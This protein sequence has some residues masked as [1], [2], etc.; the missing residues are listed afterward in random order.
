MEIY[1]LAFNPIDVNTWIVADSSG[2]CA[3]IDCG[4]YDMD[5]FREFTD[6]LHEKNLKPVLLLN[7]HC[8]LDHI[9][10]DIFMKGKYGLGA[11]CHR[12]D[13]FNRNQSVNHALMFGLRM[14]TPPDPS[15]F[16][17]DNMTFSFGT[18]EI[19][20]LH[21][22][23]HAPGSLA[24]Y[25][26]KENVVFT[27]DALF[28]GSIGRTDLPGGNYETIINSIKSRLFTLPPETIVFPGHG[29]STDVGT[30]MSSNPYFIHI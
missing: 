20:A 23:G 5:E 9:F 8:H 27:G 18:T 21:V 30:E 24:F 4:C 15:G 25:I 2:E 17:D 22:P 10:G 29:E 6:F 19:K 13:M 26:E 14:E 28:A 11:M 3:V 12:D 1:K 16:I 7:T